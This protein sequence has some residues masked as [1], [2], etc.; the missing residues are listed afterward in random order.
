MRL[1]IRSLLLLIY[2]SATALSGAATLHVDADAP[3]PTHDGAGWGTAFKNIQDALTAAVS[4]D[5]IWVATGI[6]YPDDGA[7]QTDDDRA[8]SFLLQSGVEIIGGF[9]G[10]ETD[11]GQRDSAANVTVLSG[12]IDQNDVDADA[13]GIAENPDEIVGANSFHVVTAS[14]VD[15]TA[16]LDGF[17][18]TAG[19]ADGLA[20]AQQDKG[21]GLLCLTGTTPVVQHC[22]LIGNRSDRGGAAYIDDASPT[23]SASR[24]H[25][26]A[27]AHRRRRPLCLW[28]F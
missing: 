13:N 26:N 22:T 6:Y 23:I 4:G 1:L 24:F 18:I 16:L 25:A 2:L 5:Q 8:A 27:A 15:S 12:D 20:T 3:G 17:T 9:K 10:D 21:A 28:R 7:S 19:L 11:M 14:S